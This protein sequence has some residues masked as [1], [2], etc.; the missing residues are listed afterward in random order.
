M[1]CIHQ[2]THDGINVIRKSTLFSLYVNLRTS[3]NTV[4]WR[5]IDNQKLQV[6]K[7]HFEVRL[8]ENILYSY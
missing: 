8:E 7:N 1:H 2:P 3:L 5:V 6:Q 4:G